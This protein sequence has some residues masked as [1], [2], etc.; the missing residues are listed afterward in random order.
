MRRNELLFCCHYISVTQQTVRA[1]SKVFLSAEPEHWCNVTAAN[2]MGNLSLGA[3]RALTIPRVDLGPDH[4]NIVVY[5]RC[6]Q[7]DV[8]FTELFESLGGEWPA[9]ADPEWPV[10]ECREGWVYDR[11]EYKDT[12]VTEVSGIN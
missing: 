5:E 1:Y 2:S 7:Y 6:L 11:S 8:N 12:L 9:E 4:A 10:T 3:A